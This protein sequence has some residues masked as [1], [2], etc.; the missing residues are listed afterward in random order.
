M[1]SVLQEALAIEHQ[2]ASEAGAL[3]YMARL[4]VQ[5]T[6]PHKDPGPGVSTF[7]RSNGNFHLVVMAPPRVGLPWG[8][9]PRLLLSWLT[10]EAVR[11]RSPYLE[12]G[13]NLSGFMRELGLV[14]TGGRWGTITRLRDQV[15]RLFSSTI[16]CSYDAPGRFEDT[17]FLV[18][19]RISLWWNPAAPNQADLF[20]SYVEL[21]PDFFRALV[22]RPVPVDLRVLRALRSP[23][24]LDLYCWLTYR[25]SY[26]QRPV[27]IPW[28]VLALQFGASYAEPRKFRY[29]FLQHAQSVLRLY[30]AARL[31]EGPRGLIVAPSSPHI[32]KR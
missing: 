23:L 12:L 16:R 5:A 4:L 17:A 9:T 3:G 7:E 14:P 10:T 6:L 15:R 21:S 28:S 20:G 24:A 19:S 26:L 30:P 18:A 13:A 27:E 32:A 8:K 11:T 2:Q 25:V 29:V 31:S 22:E 1:R